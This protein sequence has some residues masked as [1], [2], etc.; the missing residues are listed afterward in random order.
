MISLIN[1]DSRLRSKWGRDE[2]YTDAM[3]YVTMYFRFFFKVSQMSCGSGSASHCFFNLPVRRVRLKLGDVEANHPHL[4][5]GLP[6]WSDSDRW[7]PKFP[8]ET[9]MKLGWTLKNW[10]KTGRTL[11]KKWE[12]ICD[13][14]AYLKESWKHLKTIS[15][16]SC[17]LGSSSHLVSGL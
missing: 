17:L 5:L 15:I 1:Y 8:G 7:A 11:G 12:T 6:R 10:K 14:T 13:T 16:F 3:Y 9:W 2:I 4:G